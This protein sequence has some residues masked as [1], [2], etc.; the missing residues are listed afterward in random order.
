MNNYINKQTNQQ[1]QHNVLLPL[2]VVGSSASRKLS[3]GQR[4]RV[5]IGVELVA[6]PCLLWLDEPTSGLD[7]AVASKVVV[8]LQHS[9]ARGM[10]V[11]AVMHQPRWAAGSGVLIL[12][13]VQSAATCLRQIR[14]LQ[15]WLSCCAV[16][17]K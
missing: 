12:W 17:L 15:G 11:L 16:R 3:G 7:A 14:T 1:A 9:S 13:N 8:A 4:K 2:Q 10:N 5:A 6:K